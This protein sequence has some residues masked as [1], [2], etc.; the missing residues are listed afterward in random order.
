[1]RRFDAFPI[2]VWIKRVLEYIY[3]DGREVSLGKLQKFAQDRFKNLAGFAQQYLF[4][5]TRKLWSD[6]QNWS[7]IT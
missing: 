2:D 3:F 6:R 1:M 7:L 4:Y 5:F